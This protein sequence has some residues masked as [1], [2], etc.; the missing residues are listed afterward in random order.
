MQ[1]RFVLSASLLTQCPCPGLHGSFISRL[2]LKYVQPLA[3]LLYPL[4]GHALDSHHSFVVE[5]ELGKDT[6]LGF[7][8]DDSEVYVHIQQLRCNQYDMN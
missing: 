1:S 6:N 3:T 4:L 2:M 7:H 8:V 5:Y